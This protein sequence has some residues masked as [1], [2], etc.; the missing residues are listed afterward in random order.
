MK[1]TI[2]IAI[3][4][5]ISISSFAQMKFGIKT[6]ANISKLS[7]IDMG[8]GGGV[9]AGNNFTSGFLLGGYANYSFSRL[10]GIQPELD[11]SM[12]GGKNPDIKTLGIKGGILRFNYMNLPLLLDIKPF[13][14]SFSLLA[15]P[16]FGYCVNRSFYDGYIQSDKDYKDFD[17]SVVFGFQFYV[18]KN[19]VLGLRYNHGLIQSLKFDYD[20]EFEGV[21]LS[22]TAKGSRNIV[23]QLSAGWTF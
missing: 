2:I 9:T 18:T 15:G 12:Q 17:F 21:N 4:L 10:L 16:Q 5:C 20:I 3:T 6:G 8:N 13:K 19:L 22:F 11:F 1:R 23:L 7:G 14:S